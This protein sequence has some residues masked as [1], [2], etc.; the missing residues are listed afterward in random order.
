MSQPRCFV[1]VLGVW[2][3]TRFRPSSLQQETLMFR[4]SVLAVLAV[5]GLFLAMPSVL[6]VCLSQYDR[7]FYYYYFKT[8]KTARTART[9]PVNSRVFSVLAVLGVYL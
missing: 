8:P 7:I 5:L 1:S 9:K 6:Y 3:K 4:A 2:L